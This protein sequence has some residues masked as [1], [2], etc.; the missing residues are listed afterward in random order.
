MAGVEVDAEGRV[1]ADGVQ[2]AA[3]RPEV[4]GNLA[5]VDLQAELDALLLYSSMIGPQ[6]SANAW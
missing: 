6:V 1:I 2:G 4:V 3:R 5:G